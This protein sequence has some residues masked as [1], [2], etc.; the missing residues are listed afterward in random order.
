M[1]YLGQKL[2]E[3]MERFAIELLVVKR[4]RKWFWVKE[5]EEP[6]VVPKFAVLPKRWVV[7]RTFAWLGKF[8][9]LSKDYEFDIK[10]SVVM[11]MLALSRNLIKRMANM[12]TI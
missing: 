1:G 10:T 12:S 3:H 5:G 6:P 7:E 2:A 4:P 11:I 8:R 9:R